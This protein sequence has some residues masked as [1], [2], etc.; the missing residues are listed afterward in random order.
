MIQAGAI[1]RRATRVH[2]VT[3]W[4]KPRL[5]MRER[6]VDSEG[7]IE[8]RGRRWWLG[9]EW[10]CEH[11]WACLEAGEIVFR[12]LGMKRI[13]PVRVEPVRYTTGEEVDD[14][15]LARTRRV[16]GLFRE[17][18]YG[19]TLQQCGVCGDMTLLFRQDMCRTC[20]QRERRL[21]MA[22]KSGVME[23]RK[24]RVCRKVSRARIEH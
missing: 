14:E 17:G 5:Y 4:E 2:I 8:F 1:R 12:S 15:V 22:G 21:A 19:Q 18:Y 7:M 6:Y 9:D 13:E 10:R 16:N 11:I 3:E 23:I 20:W 24:G